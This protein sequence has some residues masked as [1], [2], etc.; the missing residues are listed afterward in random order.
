MRRYTSAVVDF[1]TEQCN[2]TDDVIRQYSL[3]TTCQ[4]V[5]ADRGAE[6][7]TT[8][9]EERIRTGYRSNGQP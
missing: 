2:A 7:L 9:Q 6:V 5:S 1:T 4:C 3:L 8:R